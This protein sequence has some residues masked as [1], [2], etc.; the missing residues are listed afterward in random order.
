MPTLTP[1][2]DLGLSKADNYATLTA[3]GDPADLVVSVQYSFLSADPGEVFVLNWLNNRVEYVFRLLP[4]TEDELPTRT[5]Q[6]YDEWYQEL[7]DN[8]LIKNFILAS[9]WIMSVEEVTPGDFYLTFT[10]R[11]RVSIVPVADTVESTAA[12][13]VIINTPVYELPDSSP[14]L[15]VVTLRSDGNE[16][17]L[18]KLLAEYDIYTLAADF[19][20]S[21][22]F[23]GLTPHLPAGFTPTSS[24]R[25]GVASSAFQKYYLRYCERENSGYTYQNFSGLNGPYYMLYGGKSATSNNTFSAALASPIVCH[26]YNPTL[27]SIVPKEVSTNQPDWVYLWI[28]LS[29]SNAYVSAKIYWSDGSTSDYTPSHSNQDTLSAHT[30]YW[31]QAGYTQMRL[32]DAPN[33]EQLEIVAYD[34]QLRDGDDELLCSVNF[35]VDCNCLPNELYLLFDTGLGGMETVRIAGH[36]KQGYEVQRENFQRTRYKDYNLREG[37]LSYFNQKGIQQYQCATGWY[38]AR[39]IQHLRQLLL[40]ECWWADYQNNRFIKIQIDTDSIQDVNTDKD[41]FGFEFT[42]KIAGF[43]TAYNNY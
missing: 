19:N 9:N 27:G 25:R 14:V 8:Y 21:P 43:D 22:A 11:Y 12:T 7:I 2:P 6:P 20:I 41:L 40:A 5:G 31:F 23:F 24:L 34:W 37:E 26:N 30:L 36:L 17:Y 15:S 33:P 35:K 16:D 28:D 3:P 18:L 13:G 29:I 10:Y 38:E 4:D 1:P 32:V 42:F 39:Y